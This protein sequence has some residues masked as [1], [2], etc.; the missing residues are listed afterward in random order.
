[1][2]LVE[3]SA[4]FAPGALFVSPVGELV[5]HHGEGIRAYLRIAQ[6]FNGTRD[7]PQHVGQA[8]LTHNSLKKLLL[9]VKACCSNA[10]IPGPSASVYAR[11][12]FGGQSP[13]PGCSNSL[14]KF[15]LCRVCRR[16][17]PGVPSEL[18]TARE[19][20]SIVAC[21]AWTFA[22]PL[23]I[24]KRIA[25][26]AAFEYRSRFLSVD[27]GTRTIKEGHDG[28]HLRFEELSGSAG[29]P[30]EADSNR[31]G[32]CRAF[33]QPGTRIALLG[34]RRGDSET[35]EGRRL[36]GPRHRPA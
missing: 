28:P 13:L 33:G 8:L 15:G 10:N 32:P 2:G 24:R 27:A 7:G 29:T 20:V 30:Q 18:C 36:G 5:A 9:I 34:Y 35:P 1:M 11:R 14:K 26:R 6:H 3:E 19:Q 4:G 12:R 21:V 25:D 22:G 16:W 17:N 23:P 31:A